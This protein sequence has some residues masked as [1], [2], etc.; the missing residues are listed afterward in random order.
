MTMSS[1]RTFFTLPIVQ[2]LPAH[3]NQTVNLC[4]VLLGHS[5][6]RARER[7]RSAPY[8]ARQRLADRGRAPGGLIWRISA[9]A[10]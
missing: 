5:R 4:F 1:A 7:E 10:Q 8:C 3:K 9:P 2:L 6:L